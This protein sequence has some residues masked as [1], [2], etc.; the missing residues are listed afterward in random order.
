MVRDENGEWFISDDDMKSEE[1]ISLT[2]PE[3]LNVD[4][5]ASDNPSEYNL[6]EDAPHS[7]NSL[8]SLEINAEMPEEMLDL[9]GETSEV[10]GESSSTYSWDFGT[11]EDAGYTGIEDVPVELD[12]NGQLE[13]PGFGEV[14]L[15]DEDGD[16]DPLIGNF[17]NASGLGFG[18]ENFNISESSEDGDWESGVMAVEFEDGKLQIPGIGEIEILDG[19]GN[20]AFGVGNFGDPQLG[21]DGELQF[22][23]I[24]IPLDSAADDGAV[25]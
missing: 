21:E 14:N 11:V 4:S 19:E 25:I 22:D 1:D 24:E 3:V 18:N 23:G 6:P 7:S 13:I 9:S 2:N 10:E 5:E 17:M 16:T 15:F 12:D 8:E 20:Y